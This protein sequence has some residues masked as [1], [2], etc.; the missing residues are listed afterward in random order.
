[1]IRRISC[2]FYRTLS[3]CL[4]LIVLTLV[5]K[6]AYPA[7]GAR[8]GAWIAGADRSGAVQAI[9]VFFRN[10]TSGESVKRAVE[11][12]RETLERVAGA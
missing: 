5:L 8:V 2:G 4:L 9:A 7:F 1:M 3:V 11:V 12:F 10:I 6:Q